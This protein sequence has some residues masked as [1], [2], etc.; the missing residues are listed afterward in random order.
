MKQLAFF[1]SLMW[2]TLLFFAH[3]KTALI[4]LLALPFLKILGTFGKVLSSHQP[5]Y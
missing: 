5:E 1:Q 2:Q 3:P 4:G